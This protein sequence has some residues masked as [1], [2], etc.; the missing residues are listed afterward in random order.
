MR[1]VSL[2]EPLEDRIAPA[3]V[4]IAPNGKSAS[5]KD[6]A[7][8]TILVTTTK[9]AFTYLGSS[10]TVSPQFIFNTNDSGQLAELTLAGIG[11]FNG[12][13]ITFSITPVSGG[14]NVV[15]VG[16]IDASGLSLGTVTVP[17]DLGR[18]D[19]GGGGAAMAL[20]AL[21][22]KS[23]GVQAGTQGGLSSPDLLSNIT[24]TVGTI[25][26]AGD[27]EGAIF[28][29]DFN[30]HP[31][32][33][34]IKQLNVG[35]SVNGNGANG[36]PG[37]VFFTGTLGNAV[38]KGGIEG[39]SGSFTG[40]IGGYDSLS[41]GFGTFSKIGSIT[42]NGNTPDQPNPLSLPGN[43][44]ASILGGSGSLSGSIAAVTVGTV[45]IAGDIYGGTGTAS[46]SIEAGGNLSNV[47]VGGSLIGGN[48]V[49]GT[50]TGAQSSGLIFGGNIGLVTIDQNI[51]G[52]SGI[53]S[54]EISS[55]GVI[56]TVLVKG[57]VAGGSAGNSTTLGLSGAI[58]G[59][60]IRTVT[61]DGSLIGGNAAMGDVNQTGAS[62]GV[63][64]SNTTI[65]SIYIHQN[66]VG[67][68]GPSSGTIN[69][70]DGNASLIV[71]GEAGGAGG[72]ILGGSGASSGGINVTGTIGNVMLLRNL[73]GGSGTGSGAI[74]AN[75]VNSLK[76]AGSVLGGSADNSGEINVSGVLTNATVMGA[77][78][79]AN[80]T[81]STLLTNTGYLQAEGIGTLNLGSL[82]A[83]STTG[84]GGLNSSGA[85]RST[86]SIGVLDVGTL[87]GNASNPAIIS[88]VGLTNQSA[89]AKT[90]VAIN[91]LTVT[92][93]AAKGS[94]VTTYADILAGYNVDTSAT[95]PLG[96]GVSADAQIN[97]VTIDGNMMATN[98]IAGVEAG[99]NGFGTSSS[100][101]LNGS[102]VM[103]LPSIIS[104]ISKIIITGTTLPAAASTD[105]YGIAAQYIA[106]ASYD[107]AA[108]KLT[109]G[110]DN[111]TFAN[112][113]EHVL[114][115]S[116]DKSG[117]V[118][119][120][121]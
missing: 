101:A 65:G 25:N 67:G 21:N 46:G 32:T 29:Q 45:R 51:Y 28:A 87:V 13:T 53:N 103:D 5:Y 17:G 33:G 93:P 68:S 59:E 84:T 75:Q 24:G 38:I 58:T 82:V 110:P 7:G 19:V 57:D 40:S 9:G 6:S 37:V 3:S 49:S 50:P 20:T 73:G 80:N 108:L 47:T 77:I 1:A 97:S 95:T 23:L 15:N 114:G 112:H 56:H 109:T 119:Y 30:S 121:V 113:A 115:S 88:A 104:T 64:M 72:S 14:T 81:T 63:I 39:G 71:I 10:K 78:Q 27:L 117:T 100:V 76:I 62:D 2:I 116:A 31:G 91:R 90:D 60:A 12:A 105:T 26:V 34:N 4:T 61:I 41:G 98:I 66:L 96:A 79:G 120:E 118:L 85:V 69:A 107:G 92:G 8:D 42:V 99:T 36:G 54:G 43:L 94:P 102:G 22:I 89:T 48:F 70:T 18:I 16:Y 52:G 55:A 83:G 11:S 86:V 106:S 35:G 74:L 44:G 111:D